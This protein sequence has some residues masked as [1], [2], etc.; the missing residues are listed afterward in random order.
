MANLKVRGLRQD[1]NDPGPQNGPAMPMDIGATKIPDT[2]HEG[3][4]TPVRASG[5]RKQ[6][7][8]SLGATQ[9]HAPVH[10][11]KA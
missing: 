6:P 2:A 10:G 11:R 9:H 5:P 7:N 1:A 8:S 4:A 3:C